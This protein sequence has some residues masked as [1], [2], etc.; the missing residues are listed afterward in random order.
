MNP[1]GN[2]RRWFQRATGDFSRA[3]ERWCRPRVQL[4]LVAERPRKLRRRRLYVSLQAGAPAF[5]TMLCPCGCGETLNLR[6]FGNRRP[7]WSVAWDRE[8]RPTVR[9]SIWR[10]TGCGSHFNLVRGRVL[11]C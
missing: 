4:E 9:P 6:F 5:G 3:R 7:R 2:M 8:A 1:L 11:W 10:R